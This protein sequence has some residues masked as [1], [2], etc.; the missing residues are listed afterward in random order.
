MFDGSSSMTRIL[1]GGN[2]MG[3]IGCAGTAEVFSGLRD[4]QHLIYCTEC[5]IQALYR[6]PGPA[7]GKSA[8]VGRFFGAIARRY[9]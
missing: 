5:L 8:A 4:W 3:D 1:A 7:E 9:R 6:A 2:G